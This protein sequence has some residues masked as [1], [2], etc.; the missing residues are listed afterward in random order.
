MTQ[1]NEIVNNKSEESMNNNIVGRKRKQG[2]FA[3]IDNNMFKDERMSLK[4]KGLLGYL[5]TCPENWKF[6]IQR[7]S[8]ILKEGDFALRSAVKELVRYGYL[9]I[10]RV[11]TNGRFTGT[12]WEYSDCPKD[13]KT[14]DTQASQPHVEKQHMI[15]HTYI[16][17]TIKSNTKYLKKIKR[18]TYN[19]E[20]DT[21]LKIQKEQDQIMRE[22]FLE[23]VDLPT[24]YLNVLNTFS[25]D[26]KDL[27]KK[28]GLL[29]RAKRHV[30]K[31]Y[32]IV[33]W[34]NRLRE[35]DFQDEL[36]Q[37]F[38][39]GNR[40]AKTNHKIKSYDNYIFGCYKTVF[41]N[42]A[43]SLRK[44][45]KQRKQENKQTPLFNWLETE[46]EKNTEK[47]NTTSLPKNRTSS[48]RTEVVPAWLTATEE[49][50]KE[51]CKPSENQELKRKLAKYRAQAQ[52]C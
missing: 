21:S 46:E 51:A 48:T 23:Y 33:I 45:A 38:V 26:I 28:I 19:T 47:I 16:N 29:F 37:A 9:E 6:S 1:I 42:Y 18:E 43:R 22:T 8:K 39:N 15:N 5:H 36:I 13:P 49:E 4:A 17:N 40:V 52:T 25:A 30:E 31:R 11:R 14:T 41:E 24:K 7:L 3:Q 44:T 12:V 27:Q 34:L 50:I 2:N 10:K 20:T 35:D 32:N